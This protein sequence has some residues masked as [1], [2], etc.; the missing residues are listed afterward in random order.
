MGSPPPT[1]APAQ[2]LGYAQPR[3]ATPV[4][5]VVS[6]ISGA[7]TS[8]RPGYV[9]MDS[10]APAPTQVQ[11]PEVQ[12]NAAVELGATEPQ[13]TVQTQPPLESSSGANPINVV[14]EVA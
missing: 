2:Q 4:S 9:E 14:H 6:P 11:N 10:S 8:P 7:S 1:Y 3:F 13:G 5:D 12:H